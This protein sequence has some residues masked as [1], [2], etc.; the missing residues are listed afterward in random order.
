M[1]LRCSQCGPRRQALSDRGR[2][3]QHRRDQ[4]CAAGD[5]RYDPTTD[6][7]TNYAP[8]PTARTAIGGSLVTL[9]GQPRIEV[10]GGTRPGNNLQYVP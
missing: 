4:R 2:S 10:I 1:A 3:T 7:W 6:R 8:P 9:N 5:H